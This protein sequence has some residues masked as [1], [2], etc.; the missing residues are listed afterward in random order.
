VE[1]PLSHAILA[2][3]VSSAKPVV[4]DYDGTAFTVK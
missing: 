1:R 2:G 4:I 3:D